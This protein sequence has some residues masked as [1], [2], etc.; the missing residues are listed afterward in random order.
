MDFSKSD[1]PSPE[2]APLIDSSPTLLWLAQMGCLL[3][4]GCTTGLGICLLWI[5]ASSEAQGFLLFPSPATLSFSSS[6]LWSRHP[7]AMHTNTLLAMPPPPTA[8]NVTWE[9]EHWCRRVCLTQVD[10][11]VSSWQM[12][13]V[14]NPRLAGLPSRNVIVIYSEKYMPHIWC[15]IPEAQTL[16]IR[17]IVLG[18]CVMSLPGIG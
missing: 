9:T 2:P 8:E 7:S 17:T 18:L 12:R 11:L 16:D 14:F 13:A 3:D 4:Q 15:L 6:M 10:Q 1:S 5:V